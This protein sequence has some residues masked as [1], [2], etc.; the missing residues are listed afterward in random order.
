VNAEFDSGARR[1]HTVAEDLSLKGPRIGERFL[2]VALPD[3]KGV[4]V[5]LHRVRSGRQALVVFYRSAR[6]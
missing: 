1:R 2:D 3:Q 4:P 6:W 5:D